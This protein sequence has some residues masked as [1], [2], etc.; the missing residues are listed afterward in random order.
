MDFQVLQC[1]AD[2]VLVFVVQVT[3]K[4]YQRSIFKCV[5][6]AMRP[7]LFWQN[8]KKTQCI[9]FAV[10]FAVMLSM[11]LMKLSSLA[12]SPRVAKFV[13]A[14]RRLKVRVFLAPPDARC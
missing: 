10:T 13:V 8:D 6:H 3:L 11:R 2:F 4:L 1:V 9:A 7:I 14:Q 12:R 5:R